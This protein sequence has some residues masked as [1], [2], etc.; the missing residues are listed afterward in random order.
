MNDRSAALDLIRQA[1]EALRA[2]DRRTARR[3]AERAAA[4]APDLEEPWLVLAAVASPRASLAYVQRALR[5]NPHSRSGQQALR[6][7]LRRLTD[8]GATRPVKVTSA[9]PVSRLARRHSSVA[10]P[11]LVTGLLLLLWAAWP[12]SVS[13]AMAALLTA[14]EAT[15]TPTGPHPWEQAIELK[16]TYTPTPTLTPTPT[17]TFT[18]TPTP[19]HT[20]TPT[21]TP[22]PTPTPEPTSTPPPEPTQT[23]RTAAAA[24]GERW[25]DVDLS[26]Q[27]VYAYEGDVV[28]NSFIVST[29][30]WRYPTVTGQFRIYVKL[31]YTDMA[32][33]G[34]YLP[35]V[36]YTMYFYKGYALHGTYWHNNFGTPMSHGC[37][38]LR[39]SDAEW[40][41]NWAS[42]GTLVN[43]H[44]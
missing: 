17:P 3:L 41:F 19:T 21:Q 30:T 4:L 26:E 35:D 39:T 14:P 44:Q 23:P 8:A 11:L 5:L 1:R 22:L 34:Y 2:G 42:V 16:P 24:A 7:A 25:I 20:P 33:P 6:W 36:P 32:G 28:V 13:P 31:R 10:L 18:P 38:N 12:G 40:L 9:K 37:I 27:R 29:G 15:P 43:V